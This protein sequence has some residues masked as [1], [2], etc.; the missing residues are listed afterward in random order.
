M[1]KI[2]TSVALLI[3]VLLHAACSYSVTFVLVNESDSAIEI[4]YS[5][6]TRNIYTPPSQTDSLAGHLV[7]AR[8]SLLTWERNVTHEDWVP[9][10][11]EQYSFDP[12]TGTVKFKIAPREAVR[13]LTAGDSLFFRD[14]Y[15]YFP[16]TKLEIRGESG[17]LTFEGPQLFKQFREKKSGNYFIAYGA[18]PKAEDKRTGIVDPRL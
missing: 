10:P 11:P 9:V 17:K 6:L 15:R 3:L 13:I 7:P 2:I 14:G 8:V 1:L 16:I 4:E 5:I 12:K 18:L